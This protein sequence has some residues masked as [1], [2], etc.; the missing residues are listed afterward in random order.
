MAST[1]TVGLVRLGTI[2]SSIKQL[3]GENLS[4]MR[5]MT[6]QKQLNLCH[7]SIYYGHDSSQEDGQTSD[8]YL[9]FL[10]RSRLC[11]NIHLTPVWVNE[12]LN[13]NQT[14]TRDLIQFPIYCQCACLII[15]HSNVNW[16]LKRGEERTWIEVTTESYVSRL[17]RQRNWI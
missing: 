8:H 10:R 11:L 7:F 15:I 12:K 1:H 17:M 6:E 3:R 5:A 2:C 14:S 9:L 4:L 16:I 13:L